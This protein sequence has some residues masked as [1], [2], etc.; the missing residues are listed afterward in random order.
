MKLQSA[1]FPGP[2]DRKA[3]LVIDIILK[4]FCDYFQIKD[5]IIYLNLYEFGDVKALCP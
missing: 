4:E 1:L 2:K 3:D 5:K